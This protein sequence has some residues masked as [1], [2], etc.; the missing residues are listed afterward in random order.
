[1]VRIKDIQAMASA[2]QNAAAMSGQESRPPQAP[3][4]SEKTK[5]PEPPK[6]STPDFW[7]DKGMLYAT[8][9]NHEQAIRFFEKALAIDPENSPALFNLGLSYS[10]MA[11]YDQAVNFIHQALSLAPDN[12]DYHYGLGWV[13][14]L[15]GDAAAAMPHMRI[16]ADLGNPDARKYLMKT[17]PGKK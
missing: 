16:A 8:Y 4:F 6:E 1:V 3:V 14:L 17:S 2:F 5:T 10:S 12:G 11:D 9:G 15:K 13:Y 7:V